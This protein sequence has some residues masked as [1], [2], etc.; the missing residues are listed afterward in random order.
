MAYCLNRMRYLL[1]LVALICI[2]AHAQDT[3]QHGPLITGVIVDEQN[4]PIPYGNV[5]VHNTTDSA[6]VTGGVSDDK[7]KFQVP[8]KQGKYFLN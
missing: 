4:I 2:G 8:V 6:L 7:G 5:A 3:E 1:F